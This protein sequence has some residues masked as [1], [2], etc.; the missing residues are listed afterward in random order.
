[1]SCLICGDICRCSFAA[2]AGESNAGEVNIP[3]PRW[4]SDPD[5]TP[6]IA[7]PQV[8]L[9]TLPPTSDLPAFEKAAIPSTEEEP[10][11]GSQ[12][13]RHEVAARLYR[14]QARRKP[15]PPRY[16]SLRL[17]FEEPQP[18]VTNSLSEPQFFPRTTVSNHAL[19]LDSFPETSAPQPETLSTVDLF[20][21]RS[22]NTSVP[23]APDVPLQQPS[24]S[25]ATAKILEFPRSWTPTPPPLDELAEPVIDRPRILDAPE[26]DRY[27]ISLT[28]NIARRRHTTEELLSGIQVLRSRGYSSEQIARKVNLDADYISSILHLLN[29]GEQ[30]LV[31]AVEKRVVPVWLAVEISRASS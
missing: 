2:N 28:E 3:S 6:Q 4:L 24:V 9:E 23:S 27:L 20:T 10:E 22:Q 21:Q 18:A 13:W 8:V 12:A 17:P 1:M 26:V 29:N 7:A 14:Y 30:R 15:R 16:P 31:R 19:A 25:T 11:E 5:T